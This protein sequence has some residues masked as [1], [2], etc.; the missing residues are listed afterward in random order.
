[1]VRR[2]AA[3]RAASAQEHAAE[4]GN[5]PCVLVADD[6]RMVRELLTAGLRRDGYRVLAVEDGDAALEA[7]R[8][9]DLAAAVLDWLMPGVQGPELCRLI[10]ADPRTA[11]MPVLLLT[12]RSRDDEVQRAFECGADDYVTKPF[13]LTDVMRLV[14]RLVRDG[15]QRPSAARAGSRRQVTPKT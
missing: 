7:A 3:A 4:V 9:T 2:R 13:H 8:S 10:K 6:D 1:M 11:A 5:S 15:G 12:S 14:N